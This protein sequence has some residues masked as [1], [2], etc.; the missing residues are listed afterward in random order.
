MHPT[1]KRD[2]I[3]SLESAIRI[4]T[5]DEQDLQHWQTVASLCAQAAA[6]ANQEVGSRRAL[7]NKAKDK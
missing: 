3:C 4:L 7:A 6:S 1:E 5:Q 2:L